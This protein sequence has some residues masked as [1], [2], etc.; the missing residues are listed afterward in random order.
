MIFEIPLKGTGLHLEN[1]NLEF[2]S[3]GFFESLSYYKFFPVGPTSGDERSGTDK[4]IASLLL[5]A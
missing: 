4:R 3:V 5:P 2:A 1:R